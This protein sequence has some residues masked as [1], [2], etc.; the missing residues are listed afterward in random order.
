MQPADS[1]R[2]N[3]SALATDPALG[4][5]LSRYAYAES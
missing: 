4:L 1:G 5:S 3:F 2:G